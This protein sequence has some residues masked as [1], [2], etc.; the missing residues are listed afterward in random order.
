MGC[1]FVLIAAALP[2]G[3]R[4][5]LAAEQAADPTGQRVQNQLTK[6]ELADGWILLFDGETLFG[7]S[8]SSKADWQVANGVISAAGGE[9]GLLNTTNPWGDF[10]LK[11]D[12]R[13]EEKTNSGV[14]LR[15]VAVP[16]DPT[17]DCYELNIAAP[18]V[19]PFPTG[20]FVGRQKASQLLDAADRWSTAEVSAKG[21]RFSVKVDGKAVLDFTDAQP[22]RRGLIGLQYNGGKIE[23]RNVKL[24]PLGL[25]N[26]L[27]KVDAGP[28]RPIEGWT[29]F[30]DKK[31]VFTLTDGT[32]NVKGG[33]G[34]LESQ[35]KFGDFV[36]QIEVFSNGEHLN[37]GI[38][39]RCIPGEFLNGYECQI[40][41]GF[42]DG[43]RS[44]PLDC[45]TG[46]FY[47]RQNARRVMADDF[48]WFPLTLVAAGDHMA[49]WV[50]GY[51][52]SDWT[53]ARAAD[54]NPRKGLRVAAG[55]LAIQGHDATT[56]LSF[57]KLRAA[58]LPAR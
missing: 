35:R 53:D 26:L 8:A 20:S 7:W 25:E 57:R 34:Q 21:G 1:L 54:E 40:Q 17:T 42:K 50:N 44:Q 29:V 27:G 3:P 23:F 15:T 56:D 38:F 19:S 31:S 5:V 36:F 11:F 33:N 30:P 47:R 24:K 48:K 4:A 9:P 22:I 18:E 2:A 28:E 32:L 37:S 39:F 14:F 10:Q 6:E 51:P 58:E 41:N 43:D 16:H 13:R 12:F 46:G 49:A 52:V 55:T 45:G